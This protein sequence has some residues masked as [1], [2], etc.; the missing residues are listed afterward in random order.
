MS[1]SQVSIIK[2]YRPFDKIPNELLALT[3]IW[4]SKQLD[5][6]YQQFIFPLQ[7]PQLVSQR[8]RNVTITTPALWT[9]VG[10]IFFRIITKEDLQIAASCIFTRG[11]MTRPKQTTPTTSDKTWEKCNIEKRL[12]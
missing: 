7:T 1:S 11:L 9:I 4:T 5:N 3:L 10:Y 8:W 12:Y 6:N 2:V